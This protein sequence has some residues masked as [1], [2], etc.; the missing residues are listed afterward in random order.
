MYCRSCSRLLLHL[1][2]HLGRFVALFAP[3]TLSLGLR[4]RVFGGRHLRLLRCLWILRWRSIV[5]IGGCFRC[6]S[7]NL[8][9]LCPCLRLLP[10][11]FC[12]PFAGTLLVGLHLVSRLARPAATVRLPS[13]LAAVASFD[14]VTAAAVC[15]ARC[16]YS[17]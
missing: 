10:L 2:R 13:A 11:L 1:D 16:C 9:L 15:P 5:R 6:L 12:L 3:S 17:C 14:A 4:A 7:L 8:G